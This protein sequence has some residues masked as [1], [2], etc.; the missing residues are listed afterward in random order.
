VAA[1]NR[2]KAECALSAAGHVRRAE[3]TLQGI[4]DTILSAGSSRNEPLEE[5]C[6]REASLHIGRA[7]RALAAE[8]KAPR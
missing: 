6:L 4:A 3:H 7:L 2:S 8:R 5:S 1:P